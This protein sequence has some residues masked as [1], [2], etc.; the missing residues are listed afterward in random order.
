VA[1]KRL[2]RTRTRFGCIWC[3]RSGCFWCWGVSGCIGCIGWFVICMCLETSFAT[4]YIGW[5]VVTN[6]CLSQTS[7]LHC[8]AEYNKGITNITNPHLSVY[9]FIFD[10]Y[11]H[12]RSLLSRANWDIASV[13]S[14][15]SVAP[16][17]LVFAC[18]QS[19]SV[20]EVAFNI[21]TTVL[22][23]NKPSYLKRKSFLEFLDFKFGLPADVVR[24][25]LAEI[26]R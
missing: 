14:T 21:L 10:F 15:R 4:A 13:T 1:V 20:F 5:M 26:T 12:W 2:E 9:L 24:Q 7:C 18:H 16:Q 3:F 25:K 11:L 6:G 23:I 8:C 19:S 17:V 22:L